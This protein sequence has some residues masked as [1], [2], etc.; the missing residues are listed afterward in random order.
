MDLSKEFPYLRTANRWTQFIE[1]QAQKWLCL[2][3][4]QKTWQGKQFLWHHCT[5]H[6]N[7][8]LTTY[9]QKNGSIMTEYMSDLLIFLCH[10]WLFMYKD[11]Q[12]DNNLKISIMT[13]R[14]V[15]L[16]VIYFLF[17]W[18][19][20]CWVSLCY[21]EYIYAE[22]HYAQCHFTVQLAKIPSEFSV[23]WREELDLK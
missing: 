18:V 6:C 11:A 2:P 5:L 23:L 10:T 14:N 3:I 22:C 20:L 15:V 8:Q 12:H 21:A 17:C 4:S 19:P 9:N 7:T 13:K 1:F 16:S